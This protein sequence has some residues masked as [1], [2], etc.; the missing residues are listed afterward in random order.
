MYKILY[1]SRSLGSY[2]FTRVS[3]PASSL[4]PIVASFFSCSSAFSCYCLAPV[5]VRVEQLT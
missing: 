3:E 4:V 5:R 2:R 1:L